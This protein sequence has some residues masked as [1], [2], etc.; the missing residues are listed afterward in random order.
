MSFKLSR[1]TR[2]DAPPDKARNTMEKRIFSGAVMDMRNTSVLRLE[3]RSQKLG[4]VETTVGCG[5]AGKTSRVK[6][7]FADDLQK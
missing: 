6:N 5:T 4:A 3:P 2:A 1:H 7:G